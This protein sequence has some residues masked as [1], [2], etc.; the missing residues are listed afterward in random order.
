MKRAPIRRLP[1]GAGA[2]ERGV[3]RAHHARAVRRTAR[4][5]PPPGTPRAAPPAARGKRG[6]VVA[7]RPDGVRER[8]PEVVEVRVV[9][10]R[11]QLA[12]DH[13]VQAGAP[14]ALAE[15]AL[16]HA[17]PA[18]LA[19]HV[20]VELARGSPEDA[21]HPHPPAGEVPHAR[22]DG[23]AVARDPGHLAQALL[24]V[25]HEADDQRA[26]RRVERVVIPRQR[27]RHALA[28][29]GPGVARA[30]GRHELRRGVDRR[31]VL[32]A[33]PSRELCRQTARPAADV[34]HRAPAGHARGVGER[35]REGARV[36]AHEPVVLLRRATRTAPCPDSIGSRRRRQARQETS[37]S[38]GRREAWL[39]PT[40][41]SSSSI[42]A[43]AGER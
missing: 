31:H 33:D 42:A 22:C 17:G 4:R 14:E 24:G 34:E 2:Q 36:A 28:H 41:R 18:L 26:E 37:S 39:A 40:S 25:A 11:L 30:A 16:L 38:T 35:R 23:A 7:R 3:P 32:G 29:V 15:V 8:L 1:A 20:G 21:E 13:V 6:Q 12:L 9:R 5:G 10:A 43:V 19:D 27:L